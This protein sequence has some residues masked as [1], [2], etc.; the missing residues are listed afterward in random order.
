MARKKTPHLTDAEVK[1]MEVLWE[2]GPLTVS[3]VVEQLSSEPP[4][5][6]STVLT[7]LRILEG[8]GY[9][10]HTLDGRAF[11]Y[12]AV[13][14]REKAQSKAITHVLRR[15]FEG[16]PEL[17]VLNLINTKKMSQQELKKLWK[18]LEEKGE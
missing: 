16:S 14:A 5:A 3:G 17:L 9:V 1:L 7:T 2:A 18:R 13:V 10:K 8:K 11:V 15:F 6:Y 12:R 4:L